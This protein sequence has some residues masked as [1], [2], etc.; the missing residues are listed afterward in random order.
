MEYIKC[1]KC[2]SETPTI[3]SRCRHCGE[4]LPQRGSRRRTKCPQREKW[5]RVVLAMGLFGNQ[6]NLHNW[7]RCSC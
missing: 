3:L 5:V 7:L 6:C 4:R 1:P 2:G